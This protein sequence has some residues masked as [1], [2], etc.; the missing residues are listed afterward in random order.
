MISKCPECGRSYPSHHGPICKM[1]VA[2]KDK[3]AQ[4]VQVKA[5]PKPEP[6]KIEEPVKA[7]EIIHEAPPANTDLDMAAMNRSSTPAKKTSAEER[8]EGLLDRCPDCDWINIKNDVFC[9][10]CGKML[11]TSQKD[12]NNKIYSIADIK[13]VFPD[14]VTKLKKEDITNTLQLIDKGANPA[15]RKTLASKTGIPEIMIYRLVN[16]ADLL[17]ID[18]VEPNEA[19]LLELIGMNTIRGLERK[20]HLDIL[21]TIKAKKSLLYSKQVIILPE[22]K[23][24]K[25]WVEQLKTIEKIVV[26]N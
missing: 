8:I 9:G 6:I 21:N 12:G 1:C 15:K 17:R 7:P 26:A 5:E 24:V 20:T 2:K 14:Q 13:G 23:R 22:D 4:P 3:V 11:L 19:Y 10:H 18:G 25:K 16:Q